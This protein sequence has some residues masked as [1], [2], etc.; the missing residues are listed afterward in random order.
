MSGVELDDVHVALVGREVQKQSLA[1]SR[2]I[3]ARDAVSGALVN[4]SVGTH[5]SSTAI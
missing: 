3:E 1:V 4:R 5:T 2:E